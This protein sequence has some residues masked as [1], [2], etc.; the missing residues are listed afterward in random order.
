M[1]K[2]SRWKFAF[3]KPHVS[4]VWCHRQPRCRKMDTSSSQSLSSSPASSS[5]VS[6]PVPGAQKSRRG[7]KRLQYPEEWVKKKCKY[8]KDRGDSYTTYK[9]ER[10]NKKQVTGIQCRCRWRCRKN[11]NTKE[12]ERIFREFY[13]LA[14][15]DLQ[16]KYLYGLIHKEPVK[17]R[18]AQA[19]KRKH[20]RH[21]F[22]Y[23]V[24]M[25]DRCQVQ[26][27]K[28]LFCDLHAVTKRRVE[29]LS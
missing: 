15:H 9:G 22:T 28:K 21:T 16:N 19:Q 24:R 3:N 8:N 18:T 26:V 10:K 23:H 29:K 27:C 13:K 20:R 12:Q 14:S 25:Q 6:S 4:N 7:R 5:P 1:N 11:I 17:R 2:P